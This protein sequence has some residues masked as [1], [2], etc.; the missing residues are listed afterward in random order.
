MATITQRVKNDFSWSR[1]KFMAEA[2]K[3]AEIFSVGDEITETLDDGEEIVIVV[4]GIDVYEKNQVIFSLKDCL[5]EEHVMNEERTNAG[6]WPECDM[7]RWLNE[8]VFNRLPQELR[9]I[10]EPRKLTTDDGECEDKLW[11]FSEYEV[12]GQG[13]CDKD[14][15]DKHI[16]YYE[17]PVNRCKNIGKDGGAGW[18][19]ER[20][21]GASFTAAFCFVG[22]S[23]AANNYY[24]ANCTFGVCFG[25]CI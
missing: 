25:F 2:G 10:I 20:S 6:G 23:G 18:W 24:I 22:G 11:L 12:F 8:D 15:G 16:P 1:A 14:P 4:A 3:A 19:W 7:R 13:W 9:D 5:A 17:N 21:P